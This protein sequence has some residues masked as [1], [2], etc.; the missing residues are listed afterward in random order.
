[1][2]QS[3]RIMIVEDEILVARDIQNHLEKIGYSVPAI[4]G[5]GE[6]AIA[7]A[8]EIGPDLILMD[9]SLSRSSVDGVDAAIA[10][11]RALDIPVV[12]LTASADA[13]SLARAEVSE[14]YGYILKPFQSRELH[15]TIQIA[16][17]K[18][19]MEKKLREYSRTLGTTLASI[20]EG[21]ITMDGAG[22]VSFLNDSAERLTETTAA[23]ALGKP[24]LE[25]FAPARDG[26][27]EQRIDVLRE[28]G[29]TEQSSV[30]LADLILRRS[31]G[32]EIP[33]DCTI[34]RIEAEPGGLSGTV[35][36][37]RDISERKMGEEWVR[38][39]A[40]HD[41]LT[42]LPNR[43]LLFE[44]MKMAM[45]QTK[46]HNRNMAFLFLDLDDFKRVNDTR[47]H[48]VGD[49][50]LKELA[51]RL[52]SCVREDDMV[53]RLA[54][55]EFIVVLNDVA[56]YEHVNDVARKILYVLREP[57]SYSLHV[58]VSIGISLYPMDGD[59]IDALIRVADEAMYEAKSRGKNNYVI[60]SAAFR[61]VEV[62]P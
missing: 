48:A 30:S 36:V 18:H 7:R 20:S 17:N 62:R 41:I 23:H 21:V 38:Y 10:L 50:L 53:V 28:L 35:L 9:I 1:M 34:S 19:A 52:T 33:V 14:P 29:E 44:R 2:N 42:G 47:G 8:P 57:F 49:T 27:R 4:V 61:P 26:A 32:R 60:R 54:G 15:I 39:L 5:A 3:A 16:L 51:A 11:R 12:F 40:Y 58:T 45:V 24:L 56:A 25:T 46:R 59:D 43:T 22:L 13:E 55:D 6:D 37:F 31:D